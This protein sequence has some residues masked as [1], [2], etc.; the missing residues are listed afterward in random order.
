[1][2]PSDKSVIKLQKILQA[3]T[4]QRV[5]KQQAKQIGKFLLRL[6]SHLS[7]TKK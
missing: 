1:M 6:Y 3:D 4:G 2:N 5:S 7:D